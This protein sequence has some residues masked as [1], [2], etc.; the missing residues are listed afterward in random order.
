VKCA[1]SSR[2][3]IALDAWASRSSVRATGFAGAR[4]D[5]NSSG[6]AASS[7]G[8]EDA[9]VVEGQP[10]PQVMGVSEGGGGAR[11]A[12]VAELA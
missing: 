4:G 2:S 11:A 6:L 5:A 10:Q 8:R 1:S 3:A 9:T 7:A 12:R